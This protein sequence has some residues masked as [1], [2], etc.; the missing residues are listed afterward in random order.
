[1]GDRGFAIA[2]MT[3]HYA[4]PLHHEDDPGGLI[5]QAFAMGSD[6]PGPAEDLL[7]SWML[8]LPA[9]TDASLAAQRLFQR[10]VGIDSSKRDESDSEGVTG[11]RPLPED[12]LGRLAE[13]LRQTAVVGP[14]RA[15]ERRRRRG[16]PLRQVSP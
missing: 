3:L 8:R 13:L 10:Y 14:G 12:P 11:S 15:A 7:L 9:G 4:S 5:G 16:P 6:F 2:P 1:M